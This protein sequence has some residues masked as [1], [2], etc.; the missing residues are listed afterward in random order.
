MKTKRWI[1]KKLGKGPERGKGPDRGKGP[2]TSIT[3][4]TEADEYFSDEEIL[5]SHN[6]TQTITLALKKANKEFLDLVTAGVTGTDE[7][8]Q[9]M[10]QLRNKI[11]NYGVSHVI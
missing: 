11:A 6:V 5:Q 3:P 10:D 4:T 9:R 7:E 8:F 1:V 2:L